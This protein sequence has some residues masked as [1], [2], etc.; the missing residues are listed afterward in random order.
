MKFR[1][2][3]RKASLD[4][5]WLKDEAGSEVICLRY[6][7]SLPTVVQKLWNYRN[8]LCDD[9]LSYGD[10]ASAWLSTGFEQLMFLRYLKTVNGQF[11]GRFSRIANW[12]IIRA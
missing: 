4:I 8:I 10:Y 3:R 9:P 2:K 12:G 6:R 1:G 11:Y 7:D 5:F